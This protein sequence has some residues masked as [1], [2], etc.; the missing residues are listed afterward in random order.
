M[1]TVRP[2]DVHGDYT[3]EARGLWRVKGDF[4]GGPFVSHMRLDKANQRIIVAEIFIY[5]PDKLKETWYRLMETSLYTLKLPNER[6]KARFIKSERGNKLK[7]YNK[8]KTT[9]SES[10]LRKATLTSRLRSDSQ[11]LFRNC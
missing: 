7:H 5:S 2:I 9:E 6:S 8:W 1:V 10:A 11:D 3:L 4:M